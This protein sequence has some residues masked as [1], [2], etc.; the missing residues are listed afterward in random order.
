MLLLPSAVRIVLFLSATLYKATPVKAMTLSPSTKSLS[1]PLPYALV[2]SNSRI[3]QRNTVD[4]DQGWRLSYNTFS[5]ILPVDDGADV[6]NNFFQQVSDRAWG[7]WSSRDPSHYVQVTLD[8]LELQFFSWDP[9]PWSNIGIIADRMVVACG[10][11]FS[12]TFD[13]RFAH[14]ATGSTIFAHLRI[15]LVAAAA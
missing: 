11:G 13:M 8:Y 2:P 3:D 1:P 5:M 7:A 10:K 9:I 4:L 6:L 14:L 12:G 15:R